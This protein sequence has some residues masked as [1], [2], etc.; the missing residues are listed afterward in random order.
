[1]WSLASGLGVLI[2]VIPLKLQRPPVLRKGKETVPAALTMRV[3][4]TVLQ[5]LHRKAG[6]ERVAGR[7]PLGFGDHGS[8]Q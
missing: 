7:A 4:H 6:E 2:N 1:M 5:S 3:S 8:D